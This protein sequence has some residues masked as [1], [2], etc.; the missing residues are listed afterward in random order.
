MREL[1]IVQKIILS[2]WHKYALVKGHISHTAGWDSEHLEKSARAFWRREHSCW[3]LKQ[4]WQKSGFWG[5]NK[6]WKLSVCK[7]WPKMSETPPLQRGP[8]RLSTE[9]TPFSLALGFVWSTFFCPSLAPDHPLALAKMPV[10]LLL[11]LPLSA[12]DEPHRVLL[13]TEAQTIPL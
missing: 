10:W 1:P 4:R 9:Q 11:T 13:S 7:L 12:E 8:H 3:A 5:G 6:C 2:V